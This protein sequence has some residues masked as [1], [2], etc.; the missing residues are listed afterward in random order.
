MFDL[1]RS[2]FQQVR[3]TVFFLIRQPLSMSRFRFTGHPRGYRLCRLF[4]ADARRTCFHVS[5]GMNV[6][7]A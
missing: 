7:L 3:Y 5:V 1:A 6:Y 4:R 2:G